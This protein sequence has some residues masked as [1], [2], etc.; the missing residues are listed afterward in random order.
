MIINYSK[1]LLFT[2]LPSR[3]ANIMIINYSKDLLFTD[4]PS[5]NANISEVK[6]EFDCQFYNYKHVAALRYFPNSN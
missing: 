3:N 5:R 4:L 2:D 1:D 6:L